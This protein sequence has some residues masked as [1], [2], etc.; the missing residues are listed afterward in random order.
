MINTSGVAAGVSPGAAAITASAGDISSNQVQVTVLQAATFGAPTAFAAEGTAEHHVSTGDLNG[1][2]NLDL[3]V[4]NSDANTLSILL[5]NGAGSFSAP[6]SFAVGSVQRAVAIDDLD[7]DGAPD[8]AVVNYQTGSGVVFP[9]SVSVLFGTGT[10]SF[11]PSSLYPLHGWE[12]SVA[13]GDFNDDSY[14]DLA[15]SR[16]SFGATP[17]AIDILWNNG[18]GSF[19][20]PTT[21]A[22]AGTTLSTLKSVAASDFDGDGDL[23][24]A[25]TDLSERRMGILLNTGTGSFGPVT[26]YSVDGQATCVAAGDFNGDGKPDL[27]VSNSYV[28]NYVSIFLG[29]GDGS[30]LPAVNY[31]V[32]GN[33]ESV[34]VADF[35]GDG[36]K[37][38]AVANFSS[39]TLSVLAG[40]G[41]GVFAPGSSIAVPDY[42]ISVTAGDFNGDGKPDLAVGSHQTNN[43]SILL[44][45]TP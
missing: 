32:G 30:F 3:A 4:A 39:K 19:S 7:G 31:T 41:T 33:P 26:F 17:G 20:S 14:P 45:T 9:G 18:S 37:D 25:F 29:N 5:G 40:S 11:G 8:L 10:G 23:D 35:N 24:L 15:V 27:A 42:P 21:T 22:Y 2:S 16:G 6:A 43:I 28:G 12:Y 44:N 13:A 1:D 38:L 36:T 34:A